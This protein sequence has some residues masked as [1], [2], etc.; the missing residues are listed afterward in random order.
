MVIIVFVSSSFTILVL[1]RGRVAEWVKIEN[2]RLIW[3]IAIPLYASKLAT[4]RICL[5]MVGA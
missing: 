4:V 5:I 2:T 1:V 3:I